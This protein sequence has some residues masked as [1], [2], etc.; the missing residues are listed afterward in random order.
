MAQVDD[1]SYAIM[2]NDNDPFGV[3]SGLGDNSS[4]PDGRM[5]VANAGDTLDDFY[6]RQIRVAP[7]T[8][9]EVS[10]DVRDLL[11]SSDTGRV[12]PNVGIEV[13]DLSGNVLASNS[14]GFTIPRD[15]SWHTYSMSMNA[16]ANSEVVIAMVNYATGT[17]GN[18]LAID[19]I[20]VFGTDTDGDGI[21]DHVELDSDNDGISDFRES[22]FSTVDVDANADGTVSEAESLAWLQANVDAG[23]TDGDANDDGLMDVFDASINT[24]LAGGTFGTAPINTDSDSLADYLDLDSDDDGIADTIE[25]RPTAGYVA[26]D[27][28]VT[29][30]DADGDGI[31]D[32]F[33]ANDG[34]GASALFGGTDANFNAPV[35]TD[36]GWNGRLSG[37]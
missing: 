23:I 2:N 29:D 34:D 36:S 32:I 6:A 7:N 24:T 15:E 30:N 17:S 37:H 9:I 33:D 10:F 18:D 3:W 1:N 28:D 5:L 16:G 25:A 12:P 13:R 4:D 26:N 11:L 20:R 8:E 22:G 19:N 21:N 27:G 14:T 35:D 31:I